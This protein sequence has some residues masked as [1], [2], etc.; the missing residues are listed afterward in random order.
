MAEVGRCVAGVSEV[1]HDRGVPSGGVLCPLQEV[2]PRCPRQEVCRNR[3]RRRGRCVPF[4]LC[5]VTS[6]G[7]VGHDTPRTHAVGSGH[8]TPR[9]HTS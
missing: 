1:C 8:D 5:V 4:R 2:C 6:G 3:F 7:V 9:A